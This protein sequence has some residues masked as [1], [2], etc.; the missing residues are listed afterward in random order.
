MKQMAIRDAFD[1]ILLLKK[2]FYP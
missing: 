1:Y 2:A